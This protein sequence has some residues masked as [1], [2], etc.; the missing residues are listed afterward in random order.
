MLKQVQHDSYFPL[1]QKRN[2]LVYHESM[3][4]KTLALLVGLVLVTIIL[5]VIALQ[6]G[7]QAPK[8]DQA[9]VQ[10]TPTPDV[11]H[12]ILTMSPELVQVASGKVGS[13]DVMIDT[14]DNEVTAVQLELL[15]D[16][17]VLTNVKVVSGPALPNPNV[18]INKNDPATG[19][20]TYA[21]GVQPNQPTVK[22]T[23][24]VAK[25]T[26]TARG[27]AGKQSQIILQETSLATARGVAG[28][29][30]KSGTGATIVISSPTTAVPR[31]TTAQ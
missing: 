31:T 30:L 16:P 7:K 5:F 19:K 3:P 2:K 6:T 26:F 10:A 24:V 11:A 4:R 17:T 1:L 28:S 23:G 18:L 9:K 21:Y 20:Y 25:I 14:S 13:V 22:G 12:T 27:T 15:Y 29:V 8:M